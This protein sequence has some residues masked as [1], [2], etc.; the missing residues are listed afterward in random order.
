V[1]KLIKK[2]ATHCGPEVVLND[3]RRVDHVVDQGVQCRELSNNEFGNRKCINYKGEKRREEGDEKKWNHSRSGC[4]G[5]RA[6]IYNKK[7][8]K[9]EKDELSE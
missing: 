5:P 9:E 2:R 3:A 4:A 8:V 6:A 1:C 7:E